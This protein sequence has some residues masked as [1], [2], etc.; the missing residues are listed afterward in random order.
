MLNR[1]GKFSADDIVKC[2]FLFFCLF[3]FL[4]FFRKQVLT[5]HANCL[6]MKCQILFSRKKTRTIINLLSAILAQRVVK[7]TSVT[8]FFFIKRQ[9][10]LK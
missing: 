10:L 8:D 1:L 3:C 6:C 5:F 2:F 4:I 7:V 9:R